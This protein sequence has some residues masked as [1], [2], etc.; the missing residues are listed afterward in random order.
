MIRRTKFA[1]SIIISSAL[2]TAHPVLAETPVGQGVFKCKDGKSIE[3]TFY[4]SSVD[5]KLSDGRSMTVPQA[6]SASG[7]RYANADES[8]VFWNKGDT[9]LVTEGAAEGAGGKETYSGCVDGK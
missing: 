4:A 6:I 7:A 1:A 2:L 9:A 3:A 8:F 5:L